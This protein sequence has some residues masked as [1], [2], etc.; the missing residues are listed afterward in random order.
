MIRRASSGAAAMTF[1]LRHGQTEFNLAGRYQGRIDSPLTGQ[2]LEQALVTADG[3]LRGL[4]RND[5][6]GD[7]PSLDHRFGRG[8]AAIGIKHGVLVAQH[9]L[10]VDLEAEIA[11]Q[12]PEPPLKS[13]YWKLYVDHVLQADEGADLDFLVGKRGA[14]VPRDNH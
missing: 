13:G 2:G 6:I 12:P 1:L 5:I 7:S 8:N 3:Q 9:F 4:D 11:W 10:A 14:F